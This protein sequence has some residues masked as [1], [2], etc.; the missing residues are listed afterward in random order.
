M[1]RLAGGGREGL[2]GG[3]GRRLVAEGRFARGKM[4]DYADG[5]LPPEFMTTSERAAKSERGQGA[6]QT[7]PSRAKARKPEAPKSSGLSATKGVAG[8]GS[9][10]FAS[11]EDE[12]RQRR[13]RIEAKRAEEEGGAEVHEDDDEDPEFEGYGEN[14]KGGAAAAAAGEKKEKK[15]K[16]P[17]VTV[18][19]AAAKINP[20]ELAAFLVQINVSG[21]PLSSPL[22][23]GLAYFSAE[24]YHD[25]GHCTVRPGDSRR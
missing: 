6:W 4:A 2:A 8:D 22:E 12:T 7:V 19:E 20:E 11:L 14:A 10:L 13:A 23:L 25:I 18:A 3:R 21:R 16:K 5:D 1:R 24:L 9:S 15:P 17:R